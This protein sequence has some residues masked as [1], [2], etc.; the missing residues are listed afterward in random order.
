LHAPFSEQLKAVSH[1][2]AADAASLP[3]VIATRAMRARSHMVA[4]EPNMSLCHL[5]WGPFAALGQNSVVDDSSLHP[6]FLPLI[7]TCVNDE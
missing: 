6:S 7:T 4:G 2:T 1:A 3:C 5:Y